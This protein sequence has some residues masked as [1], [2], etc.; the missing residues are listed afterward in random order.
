MGKPKDLVSSENTASPS[1]APAA[2][3]TPH[4][5]SPSLMIRGHHPQHSP[6]RKKKN[7]NQFISC[8]FKKI[9]CSCTLLSHQPTPPLLL[10]KLTS[11]HLPHQRQVP[12][13]SQQ[14][15]KGRGSCSPHIKSANLLPTWIQNCPPSISL[16]AGS[17]ISEGSNIIYWFNKD[18]WLLHICCFSPPTSRSHN[19]IDPW[20]KHNL[21]AALMLW[22][23][24]RAQLH[25][26]IS[27]AANTTKLTKLSL[28]SK[29]ALTTFI[30]LYGFYQLIHIRVDAC[31]GR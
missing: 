30:F 13:Q 23:C 14:H 31:A 2:A 9:L 18:R 11:F 25:L 10:L 28:T 20:Q 12:G 19:K 1:C 5:P 4:I 16:R 7:K 6:Q 24:I 22:G 15:R 26:E 29:W 17:S 3:E 21:S 8:P 27:L